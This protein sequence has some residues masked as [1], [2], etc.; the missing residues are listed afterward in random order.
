M[1]TFIQP[2]FAKGEISPSL[3]GRVDTAAYQ[4]ALMTALNMVVRSHGGISN[5]TGLHFSAPVKDHTYAPRLLKFQFNTSDTYNLEFGNLYMRVIRNGAHVTEAAKTITAATT[6]NPVVITSVAHGFAN[7]D[8]VDIAGVVGMIELN[9]RRYKVANVTANTFEVKDQVTS[10]NVDGLTF[11]PYA[12]GGTASRVYEIATP[13]TIADVW[14]LKYTQ[15]ADVMTLTHSS[16]AIR[17]LRRTG[18]AAWAFTT[19]SFAPSM[20][21]PTGMTVTPTVPG[22]V[23]YRYRVTAIDKDTQ[24]ESLPGLNATTRTITAITQANPAVVTSAA[25]GFANGDEV[26]LASVG[27]MTQ[28]NGRRFICANVAANTFELQDE[29][30]TAHTAYTAG[31]TA[32]Q[33][34]VLIANGVT[35][36]ANTAAFVAGSTNTGK[37]AV[38]R[39]SNGIYGLIGETEGLTFLDSNIAPDLAT[40]PPRSR[41]PFLLAGQFPG[42]VSYYEQRRVFGGSVN[43]PDTSFYS[44]TGLHS[45]FSS[46]SPSQQD[47][48]ITA[49]LNSR[50]VNEIRHFIPG[51]D[52]I[53]LTSGSEWRVNSGSDAAFAAETL[54]QKPHSYWG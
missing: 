30:S 4:I 24:E 18:H 11:L 54:K 31:G 38:Y 34:F 17:E 28:V 41:N 10:V 48:A 42:P 3:Y 20:A 44:Q 32:N 5:R 8:E 6:A 33:T 40:S 29:N 25:H 51:N 47:D 12:S 43:R 46:S 22:A 21:F 19:P 36:P 50:Q 52:L 7:G 49:T 37:F 39:E 2:S 27:G 53:V 13:Y 16:Y 26:H 14:T 1:P 45:N 15:S 35:P 9:N 23:T